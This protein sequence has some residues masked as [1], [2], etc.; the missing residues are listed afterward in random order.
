MAQTPR[1]FK[2][3]ALWSDRQIDRQVG[4]QRDWET[5]NVLIIM[6]LHDFPFRCVSFLCRLMAPIPLVLRWLVTRCKLWRLKTMEM[7]VWVTWK[8]RY[9][10]KFKT[11]CLSQ[12]VVQA[13]QIVS[14]INGSFQTQVCGHH[15]FPLWPASFSYCILPHSRDLVY[16]VYLNVPCVTHFVFLLQDC[17]QGIGF[18]F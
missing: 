1:H 10:I 8:H 9:M 3:T 18:V 12:T 4:R 6:L 17:K 13:P 14:K 2:S 5:T 11:H 15:F 7:S 16:P